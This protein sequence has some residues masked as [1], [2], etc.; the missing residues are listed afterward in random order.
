MLSPLGKLADLHPRKVFY[1]H[2]RP[3]FL[4]RLDS[5]V[6]PAWA[7]VE[8]GPLIHFKVHIFQNIYGHICW[9]RC[10]VRKTYN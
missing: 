3:G 1:E 6:A 5:K 2:F 10:S 8:F 4:S 9:A 7:K